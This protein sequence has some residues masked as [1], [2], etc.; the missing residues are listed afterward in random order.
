MDALTPPSMG[1]PPLPMAPLPLAFPLPLAILMLKFTI[2][3]L[4]AIIPSMIEA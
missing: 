1:V 4:G 2:A 3:P